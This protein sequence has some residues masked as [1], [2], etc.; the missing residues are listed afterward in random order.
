MKTILVL[1]GLGLSTAALAAPKP[2][3]A[4]SFLKWFDSIYLGLSRVSQ[5]AAWVAST[6]VS[7]AH[8][9]ERTGANT[10]LAVFSGDRGVIETCRALLA[11][12]SSLPPIVARQ[13]D[14]ILLGAAEGPGTI[15]DVVKER[16]AAE[17]RQSSAMDGYTYKLDGK[18]ISANDIDDTLHKST[19]LTLR[20]RTWEASKEMGKALRPGLET[21]QKLRNQVARELKHASYFALQVADYDMTDKEM[22][23]ML[24]GFLADSKPLYQKLHAWVRWKLAQRYKQPVPNLIPAHW[25][26][27]RWSQE[28]T[29]VVDNAVDL[30]PLFKDKTPEWIVKTAEKFW[31]SLGFPSLPQTFWERSDLYPVPAGGKRKK[32]AHASCW[33]VDL[34]NDIR[35]LMS[36]ENNAEWFRTAHHELGHAYYFMSYTRPEV[37]AILRQGAN[38]A[39]HEAMGDLAAIAASQPVYLKAVGV[40]PPATKIDETAALL[41]E[42]LESAIPFMAWSAGTMAHFEHDLYGSDL[43][44]SEWQARWWEYVAKYQGVA[45]P[46]K[47]PADGCDACSKTHINDL[48]AQYYNYALSTVIKYQLH[49]HICKKI[50]KQDPHACNY[51]GHKEVGDFLRGIMKSGATRPWRDV[52]KE[53]TGEPLSTRAMNDYFKP[54]DSWLDGQLKGQKVG[55]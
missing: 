21:L 10:A 25:I 47:R 30:D 13:L 17:S 52:I 44:A 4:D 11:R 7:D 26:N 23:D 36:V 55:W 45:P 18:P 2:S 48:P 33:H 6:D 20:R 53:A 43:P 51:Y 5:E 29:G 37:P 34:Q 14:K 24:D 46:D 38:R 41:D 49:D 1:A 32:N 54:L 22:M 40:L 12:R 31:V 15:P 19:D 50:L 3:P 27:N 42:A 35:S 28:W 8:D 16:V 39:M 9:G